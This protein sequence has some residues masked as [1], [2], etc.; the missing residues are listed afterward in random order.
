MDL[1][2]GLIEWGLLRLFTMVCGLLCGAGVRGGYCWFLLLGF[3]SGGLRLLDTSRGWVVV[4]VRG[5]RCGAWGGFVQ[6]GFR[7]VCG[8]GC[9]CGRWWLLG[10]PL[11]FCAGVAVTPV[12]GVFAGGIVVLGCCCSWRVKNTGAGGLWR[13][14]WGVLWGFFP[15]GVF[16][17]WEK[18]CEGGFWGCVVM[19]GE[20]V[21]WGGRG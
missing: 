3:P 19:C 16:L 6:C 17:W 2:Y 4:A 9:G 1:G 13:F 5:F 14:F 18:G 8:W 12:A 20:W 7:V 11:G 10:F 15:Y 21:C